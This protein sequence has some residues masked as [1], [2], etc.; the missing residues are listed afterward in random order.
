MVYYLARRYF[1]LSPQDWHSL[2]WWETEVLLEGL[3]A[4]KIIGGGED[5]DTESPPSVPQ[6]NVSHKEG[7]VV[8]LT[9]G[10][11]PSGFQTRRVG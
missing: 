11:V 8:D 2:P 5:A 3:R 4:Q 9:G 6:G 7:P 10:A 1:N